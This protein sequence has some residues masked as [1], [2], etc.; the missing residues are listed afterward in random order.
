[1]GSEVLTAQEAAEYLRVS[2]WAIYKLAREGTVPS[3][4]LGRSLRFS[5]QA[6]ERLLNGSVPLSENGTPTPETERDFAGDSKR[7]L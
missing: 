2:S 3:L 7:R 1:M 6:L 4:R 5:R